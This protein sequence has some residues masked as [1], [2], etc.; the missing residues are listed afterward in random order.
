MNIVQLVKV[1]IIY[2][3][4]YRIDISIS[5]KSSYFVIIFK[6]LANFKKIRHT[7]AI[8]INRIFIGAVFFI[9]GIDH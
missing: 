1:T 8:R 6:A 7:S 3:I 4:F 2:Y 5:N 9:Q